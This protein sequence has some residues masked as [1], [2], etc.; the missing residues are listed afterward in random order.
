MNTPVNA[1]KPFAW[2]IVGAGAAARDFAE[3]L[4]YVT[5]RACFVKALLV[6]EDDEDFD[7][8]LV[9]TDMQKF[10]EEPRL[11]AVYIATPA[12]FRYPYVIRCLQGGMPVL[13]GSPMV[14]GASQADTMIEVARRTGVFCMEGMHL[15]FLP[16]LYAL[17]SILH[18]QRIGDL[19]SVRAS[20]SG[21]GGAPS[22]DY[23][24]PGGG[25]LQS[26]GSY[27]IFLSLLLLGEP[28]SITATGRLSQDGSDER[29]TC[30]LAFEGGR[31]ANLECSWMPHAI[32]EAVITGD[33]GSVTLRGGWHWNPSDI[34]VVLKGD[35][36]VHRD[37]TWEGRGL[38]FMVSEMLRC[39]DAGLTQSDLMSLSL[40]RRIGEVVEEI[41]RQLSFGG[42]VAPAAPSS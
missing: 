29:C 21:K 15:R 42:P 9:Y 28:L 18:T 4:Q 19:I 20:L 34:S 31:Y 7:I 14:S 30:L 23:D 16:S 25:A 12:P 5:E 17:L 8:P 36:I 2:G 13:C 22:E 10:L 40:T 38:H 41:R 24:F 33:K 37:C 1:R 35:V 6:A 27:P 32:D 3:D 26:L 39:L 11:D